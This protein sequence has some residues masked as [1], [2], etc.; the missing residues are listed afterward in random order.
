MTDLVFDS[1]G[2]PD[3]NRREPEV[4]ARLPWP[5]GPLV[6]GRLGADDPRTVLVRRLAHTNPEGWV[7]VPA[8]ELQAVIRM[9]LCRSNRVFEADEDGPRSPMTAHCILEAGHPSDHTNGYFS[10]PAQL[11]PV[12]GM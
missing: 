9:R 12:E 1:T 2:G 8:S 5:V 7:V 11:I 10:W 4:K 3:S 6:T